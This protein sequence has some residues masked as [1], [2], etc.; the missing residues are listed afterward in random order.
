M[1]SRFGWETALLDGA[2]LDPERERMLAIVR[3]AQHMQWEEL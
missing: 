1:I 3:L 2:A